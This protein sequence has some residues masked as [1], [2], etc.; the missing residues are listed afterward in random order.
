MI[1][2]YYFYHIRLQQKNMKFIEGII[3]IGSW[4]PHPDLAWN[5]AME[6]A[7]MQFNCDKT[8]LSCEIF[9]AV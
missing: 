9:N 6:N 4:L 3:T 7:C 2:R 5:A 8:Q 1:K